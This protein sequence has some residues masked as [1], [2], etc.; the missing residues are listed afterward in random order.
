MNGL[1][2]YLWRS[3]ILLRHTSTFVLQ[4]RDTITLIIINFSILLVKMILYIYVSSP[5]WENVF[6]GNDRIVKGSQAWTIMEKNIF[7][8]IAFGIVLQDLFP[9]KFN[10]KL[11]ISNWTDFPILSAILGLDKQM[12]RS[13]ALSEQGR[14][15]RELKVRFKGRECLREIVTS[16]T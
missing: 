15:R 1:Y 10:H 3:A 13:L 6:A 11:T 8:H 14:Q 7:L 9:G 4:Q 16:S 12:T 2:K 5:I